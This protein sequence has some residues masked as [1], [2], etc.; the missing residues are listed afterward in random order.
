MLLGHYVELA[1][2]IVTHFKTK[3]Q[4]TYII[5]QTFSNHNFNKNCKTSHIHTIIRSSELEDIRTTIWCV[6]LNMAVSN[7]LISIYMLV[8]S[9]L[10]Y[11]P[12]IVITEHPNMKIRSLKNILNISLLFVYW[13]L[14]LITPWKQYKI[15]KYRSMLINSSKIACTWRSVFHLRSSDGRLFPL[16]VPYCVLC[17]FHSLR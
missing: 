4:S 10:P 7:P 11:V 2:Y 17:V 3:F 13:E 8:F 1:L 6:P 12:A 16:R 14:L 9:N 15:C 5:Y